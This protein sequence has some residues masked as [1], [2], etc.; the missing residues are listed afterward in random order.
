MEG[1]HK[2]EYDISREHLL[3]TELRVVPLIDHLVEHR[4]FG[5]RSLY[6]EM[7]WLPV[8][9]PTATWLYR[10]LGTWVEHNPD[11]LTVDLTDLS[12]GLGLG[13]GLSRNSMFA[14][15][16]GRLARFGAADWRGDA[17]AV[18]RALAPLPERQLGRLSYSARKLHD[19]FMRQIDRDDPKALVK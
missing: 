4:G 7:C 8:M 1:E 19:D 10:R 17:L 13:E 3:D 6:V 5:P 14:R 15:A 11:G 12:V 18:R 16:L 9:G 2:S